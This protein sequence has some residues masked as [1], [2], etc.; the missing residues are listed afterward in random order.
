MILLHRDW[1]LNSLSK[2]LWWV[3]YRQRLNNLL[4]GLLLI[5][6]FK[7]YSVTINRRRVLLLLNLLIYN[8]WLLHVA[9]LRRLFLYFRLNCLRPLL[10]IRSL[11]LLLRLWRFLYNC[12]VTEEGINVWY[13]RLLLLHRDWLNII[14][15]LIITLVVIV[16][17]WFV[18]FLILFFLI[19]IVQ[20]I[21][22]FVWCPL[23]VDW[24]DIIRVFLLNDILNA[25]FKKFHVTNLTF[26]FT[27]TK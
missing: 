7:W 9:L 2:L 27:T 21:N 5:R 6:F 16:A 13:Y 15:P 20:M 4:N 18:F 17:L 25:H 14:V 10:V 1:L 12:L 19:F 23:L 8:L 11:R 3:V 26:L 24:L 22:I